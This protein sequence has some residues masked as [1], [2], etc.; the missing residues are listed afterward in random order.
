MYNNIINN[1]II[2]QFESAK[3][4]NCI[5]CISFLSSIFSILRNFTYI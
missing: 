4:L 3:I 5:L 2:N 1:N